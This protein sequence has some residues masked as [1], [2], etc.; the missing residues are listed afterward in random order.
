[1][2]GGL[3]MKGLGRG[4]PFWTWMAKRDTASDKR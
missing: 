2:V 4:D 1:M 3:F